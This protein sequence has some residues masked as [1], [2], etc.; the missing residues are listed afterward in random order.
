MSPATARFERLSRSPEQ[1]VEF[2]RRIG[3][4]L[5]PGDFLALHG[6][7]GAGK[8][9]LTRGIAAG[10]G[11]LDRVASPSYLLCHE[12]PGP[13]P[14]LHLDAY[15]EARMDGVLADGLVERFAGAVVVAEWAERLGAWLPADRLEL[16]LSGQGAERLLR[17][18][19]SGPE[20][21]ARL[22]DL[23]AALPAPETEG[24]P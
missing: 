2:G 12:Y 7:L 17:F 13:V 21:A 4:A 19:A 3:A 6:D 1:T 16:E 18:G 15:F 8:T 24:K 14:F 9:T 5:R 10:L 11:I 22:E 23:R 20:S